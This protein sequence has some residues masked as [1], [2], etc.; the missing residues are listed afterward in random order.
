LV[1]LADRPPGKPDGYLSTRHHG[2][3]HLGQVLV[4]RNDFLIIDFEGEPSRPIDERRARHTPLRDV[5]GMLR[6]F[7]YARWT[8]LGRAVQGPGDAERFEAPAADW[9]ASTREAFLAGYAR[10]ASGAGIFPSLAAARPLLTLLELEKAM[11]ELRYE[12]A[13]RPAWAEIP[14]KGILDSIAAA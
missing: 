5:A 10:A 12:L 6:S 8:A 1:A 2:D 4:A 13:N 7:D 3:L 14:L 11:Y 9:L